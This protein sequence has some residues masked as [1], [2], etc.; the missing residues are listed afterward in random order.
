MMLAIQAY[1]QF[2]AENPNLPMFLVSEINTNPEIIKELFS[3]YEITQF[4]N[5]LTEKRGALSKMN[6]AAIPMEQLLL[7]FVGMLIFP[8]IGKEIFKLVFDY[9]DKQFDSFINERQGILPQLL[10]KIM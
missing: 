9:D 2:F 8:F 1:H 10:S 3:H 5:L 4:R 6:Q 7:S